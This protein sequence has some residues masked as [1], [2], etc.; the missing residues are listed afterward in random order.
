MKKLEKTILKSIVK[1]FDQTL[2][3]LFEY[4]DEGFDD[5]IKY[6]RE[7]EGVIRNSRNI[8]NGLLE[9]PAEDEEKTGGGI[10]LG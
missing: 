9:E 2:K 5:V 1:N 4:D 8:M 6:S 3:P 7:L 10:N